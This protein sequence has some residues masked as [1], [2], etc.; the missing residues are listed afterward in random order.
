M[1]RAR[2]D[3]CPQSQVCPRPTSFYLAQL[4]GSQRE[5][6]YRQHAMPLFCTRCGVI[7]T[8]DTELVAHS[9]LTQACE[10][11]VFE[12]PD[13]FSKEQERMLRRKRKHAGS[14]ENKW[15]DMYKILFPDD[16]ETDIPA[17]CRYPCGIT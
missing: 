7:F 2:L 11:R 16:D 14:E 10:V 6:I 5:H 12:A 9:R 1:C 17:P 13:G 15:R 4:T 8:R 3:D